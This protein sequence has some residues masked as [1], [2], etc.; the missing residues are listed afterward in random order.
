MFAKYDGTRGMVIETKVKV[1]KLNSLD[2]DVRIIQQTP[3]ETEILV[4]LCLDSGSDLDCI[5]KEFLNS[6]QLTRLRDQRLSVITV[7]G[8]VK[9]TYPRYKVCLARRDSGCENIAALQVNEIGSE[10]QV[11]S[12]FLESVQRH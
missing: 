9:Q 4:N 10:N 5:Q 8:T 2:T 6:V 7:H 11:R 1:A 12:E 3:S